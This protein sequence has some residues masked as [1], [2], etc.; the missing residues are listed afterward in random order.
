MAI[1]GETNI[2]MSSVRDTLNGAGGSVGNDLQSFFSSAAKLNM[3]S[4][5]KPV[6]SSTLFFDL[7]TWKASGY[8]SNKCGL[9]INTYSPATF[10]NAAQAGTTGWSY[11]PPRGGTTEPMRLGDFRGYCTTAYNPIG[12]AVTN[13][14]ISNNKLTFAIDVAITGSSSTNLTLND[15]EINGVSLSNYYLGVYLWNSST[16]RFYTSSVKVGSN[17][18]LTVE[19]PLTTAGTYRWI[20]FLS[21]AAQTTGNDVSATIVSCNKTSQ[22]IKV[23]TSGTLR[24]VVPLGSWNA[25][26]T[27][28]T[29]ITASLVNS[30]SSSVTFTNI[31]VQ[32]R[33]GSNGASSSLIT[34]SSYS[35]NVTVPAN[36]MKTINMPDIS[37]KYDPSRVYWLAGYSTETTETSYNQVEEY[38]PE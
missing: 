9:T 17:A 19:I 5:Y 28:V 10:K 35:V 36:S 14:I 8:K 25:S 21:S 13:G 24:K 32:L 22:E 18:N 26:G 2:T 7:A 15:I 23:V 4:K 30:T 38:S 3:W 12:A 31:K 29:N 6:V 27:A 37:S 20:P 16:S 33:Y 1:I 11:T 34:T